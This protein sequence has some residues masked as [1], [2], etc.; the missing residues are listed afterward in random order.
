MTLN[1]ASTSQSTPLIDIREAAQLLAISVRHLQRLTVAGDFE[2][3][4]FGRAVRYRREEILNAI[5]TTRVGSQG[6]PN[7]GVG[8]GGRRPGARGQGWAEVSRANFG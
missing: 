5:G 3:L 6:L 1:N 4:K 8:K 7:R 2:A